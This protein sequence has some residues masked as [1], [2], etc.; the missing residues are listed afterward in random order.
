[1]Q[2]D[3]S[4]ILEQLSIKEPLVGFYDAP[5]AD[6]FEPLVTPKGRECVLRSYKAWKAGKTLHLTK[7]KHGCGAMH[8]LGID[9]RSRE[10]LV[11]FLC[12]E[13]GL[14]ASHELMNLWLDSAPHYTPRHEHVLIGPL[15]ADQYAYLRT[16][17]F[18]VNPDQL[19]VLTAGAI[20]YSHPGDLTPLVCRFGSGCMQLAPLFDDLEAPQAL[21]GALDQAARAD[22]DPCILAFTV[23]K[24]MFELLCRW[25]SDPS[26]S[27]H[28]RFLA[29]LLRARGG[30]LA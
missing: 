7:E 9:V 3:P 29:S 19:S 15:R 13:E 25:A 6:P 17:T 12:D 28:N 27:L 1:V 4:L 24:P 8:L 21:I 16:V 23:T 5:H 11:A 20:Y 30:S 10:D 2:P 18:Y 22:L 26:S 14:K